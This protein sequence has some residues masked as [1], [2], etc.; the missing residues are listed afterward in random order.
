MCLQVGQTCFLVC[1]LKSYFE[2]PVARCASDG[3]ANFE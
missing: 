2:Q 3:A 1:V